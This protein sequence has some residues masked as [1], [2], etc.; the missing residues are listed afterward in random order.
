MTYKPLQGRVGGI[1][2]YLLQTSR[3]AEIAFNRYWKL[4]R[5]SG[6]L[7]S[8]P[9]ESEKRFDLINGSKLYCISGHNFEDLR[10]ETLDGVIIDEYRQQHPDLWTKVIRPMLSR[11][12]GWADFYSTPNGFE[13][14]YDLYNFAEAH[15]SEW[16]TFKAPST[17][18]FWWTPEEIASAKSTMSEAEYAQEIMAE[19]RDMTSG[20]AYYNFNPENMRQDSPFHLGSEYSPHLPI[21]VTMDFNLDPMAWT[22]GQHHKGHSHYTEEMFLRNSNT[23]EASEELVFRLKRI[24]EDAGISYTKMPVVFTGDATGKANQRT[25]NK[26]DYDIVF[27]RLDSAGI[28][29]NN[30]VRDSNPAVRDRVNSVNAA[31]KD[32]NGNVHLTFNPIKCP[33]LKKDFERVKWK[34]NEGVILDSGTQRDLGHA[35]DGVGYHIHEFSP[36]SHDIVGRMRVIKR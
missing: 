21:H 11:R 4:H 29:Y 26:S 23:P 3:A 33:M 35:S 34:T 31:L 36:L 7:L 1:Y 12:K 19:F 22:I 2:W 24:A 10:A 5:N 30:R 27:M 15:P 17:E 18:A 6:L 28:R 8:K 32:A 9:N 14:F 13:H 16:S 25:S 20:R